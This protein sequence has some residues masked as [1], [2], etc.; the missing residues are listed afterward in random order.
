MQCLAA[1][2]TSS[3]RW[4]RTRVC[5]AAGEGGVILEMSWVKMTW[6]EVLAKL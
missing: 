4:A 1:C 5:V 6:G 2:S 3:R